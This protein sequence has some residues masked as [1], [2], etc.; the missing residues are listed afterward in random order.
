MPTTYPKFPF[1][2]TEMKMNTFTDSISD[3][4]KLKLL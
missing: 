2:N 1:T 3:I 4:R